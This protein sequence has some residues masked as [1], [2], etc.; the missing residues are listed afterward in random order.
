MS[1]VPFLPRER[2][3]GVGVGELTAHLNLSKR[4]F[5]QITGKSWYVYPATEGHDKLCPTLVPTQKFLPQWERR[6]VSCYVE[7]MRYIF[8]GQKADRIQRR[9]QGVGPTQPGKEGSPKGWT[10]LRREKLCQIPTNCGKS[11]RRENKEFP[12]HYLINALT[13]QKPSQQS[14]RGGCWKER[15][16]WPCLPSSTG[17]QL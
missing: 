6:I 12:S 9:E 14:G 16:C 7:Q 10:V 2:L 5:K 8:L 17:Y 4:G 3:A 15:K 13:D 1:W 11:Q